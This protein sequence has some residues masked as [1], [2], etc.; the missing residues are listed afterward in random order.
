MRKTLAV[1]VLAL[2]APTVRERLEVGLPSVLL[3]LLNSMSG[4]IQRLLAT[5]KV[6]LP[7]SG[8]R[9]CTL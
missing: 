2:A 8:S 5:A 7:S 6:C 1:A 3:H 9:I 4:H